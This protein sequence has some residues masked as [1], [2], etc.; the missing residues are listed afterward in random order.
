MKSAENDYDGNNPLL[1]F[2]GSVPT[3]S[4]RRIQQS[5]N[6]AQRL[7]AKQRDSEN[8]LKQLHEKDSNIEKLK[9][10]IQ[11]QRNVIDKTN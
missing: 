8:L 5:L 3:S 10:E 1:G 6:L 9:E 7:Q 11:I 4:K 2:M